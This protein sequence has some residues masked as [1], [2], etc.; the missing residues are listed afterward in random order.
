MKSE[1]LKRSAIT[2]RSA[3]RAVVQALQRLRLSPQ[4]RQCNEIT[5]R[6]TSRRAKTILPAE[7]S[8]QVLCRAYRLHQLQRRE[9]SFAVRSRA[10]ED[11]ASPDIRRLLS[12]PEATQ[13]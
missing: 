13:R 8:L 1:G 3:R 5:Q 6:K 12:A 11:H 2:G 7:K 10:R 4:K 9:A